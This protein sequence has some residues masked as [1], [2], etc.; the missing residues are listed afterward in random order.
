MQLDLNMTWRLENRPPT[1]EEEE[2]ITQKRVSK[3]GAVHPVGLMGPTINPPLTALPWLQ[4]RQRAA[5][6]SELSRDS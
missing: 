2:R 4:A 5:A 6:Y 1:P 3:H